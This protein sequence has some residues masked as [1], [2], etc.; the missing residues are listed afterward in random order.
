MNTNTIT[1]DVYD[2]SGKKLI[3]GIIP[4]KS[5][6]QKLPILEDYENQ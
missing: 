3:K 2:L 1:I 4:A 5:L 6:N